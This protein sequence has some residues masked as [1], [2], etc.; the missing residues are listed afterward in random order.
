MKHYYSKTAGFLVSTLVNE[1]PSDAIEITKGRHIELQRLESEGFVILVENGDVITKEKPVEHQ[2]E[3]S[4]TI[5]NNEIESSMWVAERHRGQIELG[6]KT[7][8]SDNEFK[9]LLSYHQSL[10]DWTE[11]PGWPYVDMPI[12]PDWLAALKK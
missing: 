4:R 9:D 8:I 5:R 3:I 6:I 12:A 11:H 10:R 7:S 1:I 2:Q